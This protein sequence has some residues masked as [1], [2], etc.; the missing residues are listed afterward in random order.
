MSYNRIIDDS[1]YAYPIPGMYNTVSR[2]YTAV[3]VYDGHVS[4]ASGNRPY[5]RQWWYDDM[6]EGIYRSTGEDK[7]CMSASSYNKLNAHSHSHGYD[8]GRDYRD[9]EYRD[10]EYRDYRVLYDP[11]YPALNRT[12]M[13]NYVGAQKR[14]FNLPTQF[15]EDTYRIV[16]YLVNNASS[17][18]TWKLM[19]RLID[20]HR[21][22]F[23]MVPANGSDI[24]VPINNNMIVGREKL[25]DF[26]TIPDTLVFSSPLLERTPYTFVPLPRSDLQDMRYV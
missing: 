4:V 2:P 11:L 8:H 9:A 12:R 3:P 7:V 1:P 18:P 22:D 21:G 26:Y 15:S 6:G 25:T 23:Y 24:K 19:G 10:T 5:T 20:R 17:T 16:G 13:G 14:Y